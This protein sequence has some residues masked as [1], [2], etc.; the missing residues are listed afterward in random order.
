[1]FSYILKNQR[2]L[3]IL[4]GCLLGFLLVVSFIAVRYLSPATLLAISQITKSNQIQ[5]RSFKGLALDLDIHSGKYNYEKRITY[6]PYQNAKT[7]LELV[8]TLELRSDS[9]QTETYALAVVVDY[10]Q[11]P[12]T[13]TYT[14]Y[15][16]YMIQAEPYVPME[17]DFSFAIPNQPGRHQLCLVLFQGADMERLNNGARSGILE[18]VHT[19]DIVVGERDAFP[20][21]VYHEAPYTRSYDSKY[22]VGG[23]IINQYIDNDRQAWISATVTSGDGVD[24]YI[25]LGDETQPAHPYVL[26]A[27]L[28]WHQIPL[29]NA[30]TPIEN[31]QRQTI[32]AKVNVPMAVGIHEL[33]VLYIA[34]PYYPASRLTDADPTPRFHFSLRTALIVDE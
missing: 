32:P 26:L 2:W 14:S 11:V 10:V 34:Y 23:I 7:Y 33:Q 4:S 16:T 1:V 25:H 27:W 6:L 21:T 28:D 12:L 30:G 18:T 31:E 9:E 20:E 29:G 19:S 17:I 8:A 15:S 3:L 5:E 24:Y 22:D 13:V